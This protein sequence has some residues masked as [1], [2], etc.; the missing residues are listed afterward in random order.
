MIGFYFHILN[1]I[2]RALALQRKNSTETGNIGQATDR[3]RNALLPDLRLF[4]TETI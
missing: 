2:Q 3:L 4:V 1:G